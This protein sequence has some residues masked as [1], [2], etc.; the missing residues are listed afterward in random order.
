[1]SDQVSRFVTGARSDAPSR[2]AKDYSASPHETGSADGRSFSAEIGNIE[3]LFVDAQIGD[4]VMSP[5]N[6]HF[7][8][9][10]IGEIA[11]NWSKNDDLVVP[12]LDGETVPTRKVKWLNVA[13]ARRDFPSKTSKRLQNRHA[14]TLLDN[15]YY[16]NIFDAVYPNYAWGSRSKIDL[17]GNG[18]EGKDP[19]Q[20]YEA[21]LLLKYVLASVFAFDRGEIEIFQEL[22]RSA[23]IARFYDESLV[24]DL[25][26]NFNSPGKLTV[27]AA[28][29]SLASLA[30]AGLLLA[31]SSAKGDFNSQK[32]DVSQRIEQSIQG[33]NKEIV[34]RT[35]RNYLN[36]LDSVPWKQV[37][38]EVGEPAKTSLGLSLDNSV[39]VATHR[40]ELDGN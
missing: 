11:S 16:A 34:V 39:E 21:A 31:T 25:Y 6:G 26:Q 17:F 7:E 10:L 8:P 13:L 36:S 28:M 22:D 38:S 32:A 40:A 30:A 23:A 14:I 27:I 18:Y 15:D 19:L 12:K 1:M 33:P 29:G 2:S 9:F 20:P 4:L 24:Q 37:Q 5:A 3:R 35:T